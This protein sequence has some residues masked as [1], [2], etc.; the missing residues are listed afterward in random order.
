MNSETARFALPFRPPAEISVAARADEG[1]IGIVLGNLSSNAITYIEPG[2]TGPVP[3][4][5]EVEFARI[6]V[7]DIRTGMDPDR[8]LELAGT[9]GQES[10]GIGRE[11]EEQTG[12]ERGSPYTT[13]LSLSDS[14]P[15]P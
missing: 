3:I 11:V 9:F 1:R 4:G 5:R 10:E 14:A 7:C 15:A 6:D 8:V 2:G 12:S 13:W